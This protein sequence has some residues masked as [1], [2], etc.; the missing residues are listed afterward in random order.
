MPHP[1]SNTPQGNGHARRVV[2]V[3]GEA[4][5]DLHGGALAA[6]LRQR[7][8]WISIVGFGGAAMRRAGVDVRFDIAPM[9]V[10]GLIEVLAQW[11]TIRAAWR[12]AVALLAEDVHLLIL[13][14]YPDFN[15]RL[16]KVAKRRGIAV[17]YYV[18][19]QVWAW[20]AGRVQVIAKR[21]DLMLVIFP[22]EKAIYDAASVP[23]VF[24]GHPLMDQARAPSYASK[25]AY[26]KS[27]G[28]NPSGTTLALLPGSRKQ[29]VAVLL[30]RM[31]AAAGQVAKETPALPPLQCLIPVAPSLSKEGM[32]SWGAAS[33][34]PVAFVGGDPTNATATGRPLEGAGTADNGIYDV[35]GAADVAVV[36]SG[37]ATLQTAL[38]GVPMIVVYK[39]S[40]LT[41]ALARL[42]I[43]VRSVGLVNIVA[44]TPCVPE[45]IQMEASPA[46]I[47]AEIKRLLLDAD[48]RAVMQRRLKDVAT[49]LGEAGTAH[50][51]ADAILKRFPMGN[52]A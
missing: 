25:H 11:K 8:P 14:D 3:A 42:L 29:E 40:W 22:F 2:M 21:V 36:A 50:R 47:G 30:P 43:R 32:A 51:A 1:S 41:W 52:A 33:P 27:L 49:A 4:S 9:G 20:R 17:V 10:V 13:I 18:S 12:R 7:A 37:T 48:A 34:I 5:G 46:R 38:A 24:V 15:L 45:L 16:A 39:L 26:L 6:A 28:L 31:L 44:G 23:C 35:L 19:P